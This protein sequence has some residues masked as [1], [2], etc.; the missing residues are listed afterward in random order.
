MRRLVGDDDRR[1]VEGLGE[2]LLDE[3]DIAL[4][5]RE[6]VA[7]PERSRPIGTGDP[8]QAMV[9]HAGRGDLHGLLRLCSERV[10]GAK[11]C[12]HASY[13]GQKHGFPIEHRDPRVPR[14]V[15]RF[16]EPAF[17]L[18]AEEFVVAGGARLLGT[19][20]A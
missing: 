3:G 1:A 15:A 17:H 14:G 12:A 5:A 4:V 19:L 6:G 9:P 18:A 8:D 20:S 11:D 16:R 7:R 10:V 2:F 13:A